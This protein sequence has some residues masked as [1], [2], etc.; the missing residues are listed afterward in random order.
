[1]NDSLTFVGLL[2]PLFFKAGLVFNLTLD[3]D[4]MGGTNAFQGKCDNGK[5]LIELFG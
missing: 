4:S 5:Y 3:F 1:M 2:N